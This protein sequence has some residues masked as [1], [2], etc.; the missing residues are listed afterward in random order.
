MNA[1][2]LYYVLSLHECD[3]KLT[4][5]A[6]HEE[7]E[8]AREVARHIA[9]Y[10]SPCDR[11]AV[12]QAPDLWTLVTCRPEYFRNARPTS[13]KDCFFCRSY[14]YVTTIAEEH[15][16]DRLV[17]EAQAQGHCLWC[18]KPYRIDLSTVEGMTDH[19]QKCLVV[20]E[21]A[22]VDHFGD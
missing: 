15:E 18:H 5:F 1:P 3:G 20:G 13:I 10:G 2:L 17:F 19:E 12:V 16:L 9:E 4:Y 11:I 21:I 7:D 6:A 14:L 22:G 8:E